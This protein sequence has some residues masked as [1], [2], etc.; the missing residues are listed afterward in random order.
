MNLGGIAGRLLAGCVTGFV[1]IVIWVLTER[2]SKPPAAAP[3]P[4]ADATKVDATK[5]YP[6]RPPPT[7]SL[8][9]NPAQSEI[10]SEDT[11][12]EVAAAIQL[13][14]LE[15]RA[16]STP[17]EIMMSRM[18]KQNAA[19]VLHQRHKI[20]SSEDDPQ[21]ARPMEKELFAYVLQMADSDSTIVESI[22]CRSAG[23]ELQLSHGPE[24]KAPTRVILGLRERFPSLRFALDK[25][26]L[27]GGRHLQLTYVTRV[28]QEA[29]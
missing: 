26:G 15:E 23:C 22:T 19:M 16:H 5:E 12:S 2:V 21:W 14:Q 4:L 9:G 10:T 3:A 6:L 13:T 17:Y 29:Q 11:V 7:G 25:P 1:V 20:L 28:K 18:G 24:S 27:V 8:A